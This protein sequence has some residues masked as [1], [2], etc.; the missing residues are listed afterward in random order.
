MSCWRFQSELAPCPGWLAGFAGTLL[1][2]A[3]APWLAGVPPLPAA[4][5]TLLALSTWPSLR[6]A[7]PGRGCPIRGLAA[8]P[9]GLVLQPSGLAARV[10]PGSRV[11]AGLVLLACEAGGRRQVLWIPRQSLPE[12]DFR[13][14]KVL[15]RASRQDLRPRLI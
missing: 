13:R 6:R 5:L 15:L 12:G 10:L 4:G 8:G 2:A 3:A 1:L 11:L 9:E 14:L 7:V